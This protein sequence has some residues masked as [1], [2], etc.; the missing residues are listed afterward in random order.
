M[1]APD[2]H[3]CPLVPLDPLPRATGDL[4]G[5]GGVIRSEP[6]DFV[7]DEVPLYEPCGDGDHLYLRVEK[8]DLSADLLRKH[9]AR[10]LHVDPRDI[11]MAGLKDRRAVT[12]QW[13]SVP[14]SGLPNVERADSP[15][16]RVLDAK[17]H[18]NKLRTGHLKANRFTLRVRDTVPDGLART[19]RK[20]AVL[21]RD[22]LA[23][24]YGGQRMGHGG[25]T[26]AAGWALVKGEARVARIG[27]PDG[28][29]HQVDLRDRSLRRLAASA[30]QSEVFNRTLARRL[31]DGT[32][33]TVLAG[34]VCCKIDSGGQFVSTEPE[35]DQRRV[36][37]GEIAPTG[38]MWGPRMRCADAAAGALEAEILT[39]CGLLPE[40]IAALGPLAEGT[41]RALF[42]QIQ[43][44]AI[45]GYKDSSL[46]VT[47][48]LPP[49]SYATGVL[50]ELM[51]PVEAPQAERGAP[52][53]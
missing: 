42:V 5:C 30:L 20:L 37:V 39:Q 48:T 31:A 19:R 29:V 38:P 3:L 45:E 32:V 52:C 46:V 13:V 2:L 43:E 10:T 18:R 50:H 41:R 26:L 47:F 21:E 49:G 25:S 1:L 27:T 35:H 23:N 44:L 17:L 11:G 9:L 22:G 28:T 4:P 33:R 40:D 34:D 6:A 12:R 36:D 14:K 15:Q 16:V 8:T 7:V 53:A 51:G 24:F